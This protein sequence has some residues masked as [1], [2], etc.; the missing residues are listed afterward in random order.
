MFIF[1]NK[2]LIARHHEQLS[3][4]EARL[5][6]MEAALAA[7]K[8]ENAQLHQQIATHQQVAQSQQALFG[9]FATLGESF[10]QLQHSLQHTA[11]TLKGEKQS[12]IR[13]AE[14]STQ[15]IASVETLTRGIERVSGISKES[16]DSV[17]RLA[18][19]ADKIG[20]FVS[21]IQGISE[22][23]NL[24]ALNAAIEAARAGESGR[25]FAVVADE[26][27]NLAGRTRDATAEIA[28]L[29]ETIGQETRKSTHTMTEVVETTNGFEKQVASSIDIIRQQLDISNTME[30]TISST[31]LRSFVELAKLDHLIFKFGIYKTFMGLAHTDPE[32]LSDHHH[33]RLGNWY[34]HGEGRACFSQLP[35]Y[36]E[37]E[38]PHEAVHAAGRQALEHH[39]NGDW[40]RGVEAIARMEHASMSVLT[41][42]EGMARSGETD[43]GI[44]CTDD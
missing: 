12:A 29:V 6:E 16:A 39:R 8:E 2:K 7:V 3:A 42:L 38:T 32:T 30:S 27:R 36:R 23:T 40:E 26:V 14:I 1:R 21:I 19:I 15:A 33:C 31:A 18:A 35:G 9:N 4:Q 22:Q 10:N 41:H 24:L 13:S 20:D 5:A 11:D 34:Y 43:S 25:G 28:G 37:V 44:L 17:S